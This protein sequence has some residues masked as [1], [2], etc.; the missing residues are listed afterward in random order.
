MQDQ[1]VITADMPIGNVVQKHPQTINVF[2]GH[3]MGCLGCA[4]AHFE[5]IRQGAL[6][7]GINVDTLIKDLNQAVPQA[8][9]S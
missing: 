4:V 9:E 3:G 7:H 5:N 1:G 6:A 8:Q 2:L